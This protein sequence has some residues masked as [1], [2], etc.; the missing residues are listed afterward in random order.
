MLSYHDGTSDIL[1]QLIDLKTAGCADVHQT[2]EQ[3]TETVQVLVCMKARC[4]WQVGE[5]SHC[6]E[7]ASFTRL[8]DAVRCRLLILFETALHT[9]IPCQTLATRFMHA[10]LLH[11]RAICTALPCVHACVA[12]E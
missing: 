10:R 6:V 1:D 2:V 7:A 9:G 3:L 8:L 12:M 5:V 11:D 4:L